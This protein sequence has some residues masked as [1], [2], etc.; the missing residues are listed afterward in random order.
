MIRRIARWS[1]THPAEAAW[2]IVAPAGLAAT[3][4]LSLAIGD[5]EGGWSCVVAAAAAMAL[6]LLT[7]VLD[8]REP[9]TR[10]RLLAR[11]LE[12][13]LAMLDRA[14][15][16]DAARRWRAECESHW[17]HGLEGAGPA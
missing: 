9:S 15:A 4:A 3:G 11:M 13:S 7:V 14:D 6:L 5:P 17:Q 10:E 2:C 12:E 16:D 1:R 8:T